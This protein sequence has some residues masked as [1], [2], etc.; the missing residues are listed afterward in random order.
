MGSDHDDVPK[1]RR[2]NMNTQTDL[3]KGEAQNL[4]ANSNLAI[5]TVHLNGT[6][7]SALVEQLCDAIDAIHA[8]GTKLAQACPNGRDYYPQ[9]AN[10][11]QEA[12]RQ[13]EGRMKKL[14]EI[15]DELH[16]IAEAIQ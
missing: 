5:P 6:S 9:G 2:E 4:L 7:K 8:A 11:I 16:L 10:A 3:T 1:H 12:L 14:K 13:H 15:A